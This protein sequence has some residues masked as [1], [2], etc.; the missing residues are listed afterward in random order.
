MNNIERHSKSFN[1]IILAN[2]VAALAIVLL[3]INLQG[4]KLILYVCVAALHV[5]LAIGIGSKKRWAYVLMIIYGLFQAV[6]MSLWSLIGLLTL[7]GEPLTLE[8]SIFFAVSAVV[9]PFLVW[10]IRFL[11]RTLKQEI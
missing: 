5:L 8:K 11:I 1:V 4:G 3:S 10:V 7:M 9:V 2:L 6:G